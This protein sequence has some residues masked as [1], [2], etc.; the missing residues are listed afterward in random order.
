MADK[1]QTQP[2][3]PIYIPSK[4]RADIALTPTALRMIGVPFRIVVE[5]QEEEAYRKRYGD[6]VLVLDMEYKKTFDLFW[7]FPEGSSTGSGPARNFIWDHSISEGHAWHWI[8]DDNIDMFG[9]LHKNT[10]RP[11]GD[12]M[13]F[14]AMEDFCLRYENVAMAG[15]IYSAF[16]PSKNKLPPFKLNTRIYSCNL[17]RND[18]PFRWRG[19]YNEDTDLSLR[20]LKAGWCTVEFRAFLQYKISTQVMAGGNTDAFYA[21]EGTMPKSQMLVDMH[22]DVATISWKYGRAHH[23]INYNVFTHG[24]IKKKDWKPSETNRFEMELAESQYQSGWKKRFG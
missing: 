23:N 17:I 7:K 3:F 12:G 13:G 14:W 1:P 8:M 16:A 24:L 2:R 4:G 22:P 9:R 11:L 21:D 18:V 5:P 15:P 20:M 6:S 19:R 10:R